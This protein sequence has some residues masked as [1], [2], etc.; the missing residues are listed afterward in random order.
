[1]TT[2]LLIAALTMG[3][4]G[5][6]HCLGMCGGIVA[7]FGLSMK[8]LSVT[9]RRILITTYHIGRLISYTTLGVIASMVGSQV[10][11]PFLTNNDLP[12]MLL[13]GALVLAALLM[14]GAPVLTRFEKL[15][16]GLWQSLTP[17]RQKVLPIDSVPKAL[18]AGMLWGLLPCGLVYGALVV[19]VGMSTT[20]NHA[21]SGAIFM[22]FFGLG[23]LPMLIATDSMIGLLQNTVKRFNLRKL[24]GMLMLI[25]GLAIALS[26][27]IIHRLHHTHEHD[28]G[29]HS[30][31]NLH[32]AHHHH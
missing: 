11:A 32:D 1:M 23:T 21:L 5:S 8:N 26:P 18:G 22:M 27:T 16:M 28:G 2:S 9:K 13:G 7:A 20:L 29:H 30:H 15:G 3:F 10:I 6:P 31:Q 12:R 17:I 24:S 14:L 25:S 19:S 4:F